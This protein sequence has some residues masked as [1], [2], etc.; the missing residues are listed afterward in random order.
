MASGCPKADRH[1]KSAQNSAYKSGNRR[2][3]NAKKKQARHKKKC[4]GKVLA[5]PRGTAR[6]K[7]RLGKQQAYAAKVA[8]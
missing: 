5:V 3:V 1:R 6:N 7:R 4:E 8:A 2:D